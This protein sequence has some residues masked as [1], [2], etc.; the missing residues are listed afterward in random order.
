MSGRIDFA[1]PQNSKIRHD[2]IDQ[3]TDEKHQTE[4]AADTGAPDLDRIVVGCISAAQMIA[5]PFCR[6]HHGRRADHFALALKP[7]KVTARFFDGP[8][9]R[10]CAF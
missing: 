8:Q 9:V 1:N 2:H 4:A 10:V 5:R 6:P 7:V 3:Q